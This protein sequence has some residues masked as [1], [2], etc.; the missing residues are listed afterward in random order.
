MITEDFEL[1]KEIFQIVEAGIVQGYDAFRYSVEWGVITW[2]P[3]SPLK[4]MAQKSG[5]LKLISIILKSM[6]L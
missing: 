6:R 1:V 4:K 5:T 2:R 3:T